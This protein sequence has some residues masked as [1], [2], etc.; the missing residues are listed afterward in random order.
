M[1]RWIPHIHRMTT[2]ARAFDT[3]LL[4]ESS[5][6]ALAMAP[7]KQR[8]AE[9]GHAVRICRE[10]NALSGCFLV[11]GLCESDRHARYAGIAQSVHDSDLD[12]SPVEE[13]VV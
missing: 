7:G 3:D 8:I 12:L 13:K 11:G 1:D 10:R 6:R 4:S 5:S 9:T 2:E